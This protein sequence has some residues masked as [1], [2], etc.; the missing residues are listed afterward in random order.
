MVNQWKNGKSKPTAISQ[1]FH[2]V[3]AKSH[4]KLSSLSRHLLIGNY[5]D[6][7]LSSSEKEN[8]RNKLEIKEWFRTK[9]AELSALR[10]R[11][12][13]DLDTD[14]I[15]YGDALLADSSMKED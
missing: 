10:E 15:S 12:Q 11:R 5:M 3:Y 7:D 14:Y 1:A 9:I 13:L 8:M 4:Q 2:A 6:Y